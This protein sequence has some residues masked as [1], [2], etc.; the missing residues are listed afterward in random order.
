MVISNDKGECILYMMI[1]LSGDSVCL[2]KRNVHMCL[3]SS[4][5]AE[6]A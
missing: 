5:R 4:E 3:V 6:S 1:R 2:L